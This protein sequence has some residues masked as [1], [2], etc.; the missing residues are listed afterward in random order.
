[1]QLEVSSKDR[2]PVI[3]LLGLPF[4]YFL[5]DSG[6]PELYEFRFSLLTAL[7]AEFPGACNISES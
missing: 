5:S 4:G 3:R 7:G 2:L 1:M 6:S